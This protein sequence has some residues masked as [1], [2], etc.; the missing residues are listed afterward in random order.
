MKKSGETPKTGE[1]SARWISRF[2]GSQVRVEGVAI[3]LEYH[4]K[5]AGDEGGY[6]AHV[7]LGTSDS[8]LRD[9]ARFQDGEAARAGAIAFARAQ[10]ES[11]R[12]RFDRALAA[13]DHIG[14]ELPNE[15]AP[16]PK[17]RKVKR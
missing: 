15:P 7:R 10:I 14:P 12:D 11:E 8:P 13:L 4:S 5:R 2:G 17:R 3:S 6:G 9:E 1:P 16:L